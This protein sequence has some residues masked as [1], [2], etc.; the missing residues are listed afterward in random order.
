V[1]HKGIVK[2]AVKKI[3][4]TDTITAVKLKGRTSKYFDSASVHADIGV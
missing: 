4:C 3:V 2:S 1:V